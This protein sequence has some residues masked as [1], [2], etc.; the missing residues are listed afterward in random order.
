MSVNA[1]SSN[2]NTPLM[3]AA[4]WG[5]MSSVEYLLGQGADKT[6]VNNA[7][8]NAEQIARAAGYS[9]VANYIRNYVG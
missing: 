1:Q 7:N 8:K 6:I 5:Q 2:G 4:L 9:A 3:W